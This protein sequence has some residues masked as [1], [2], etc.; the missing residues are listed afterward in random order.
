MKK[1]I[2]D[3]DPGVDDSIAIA[4]SIKS[5]LPIAAICTVYGNC[6]TNESTENTLTILELVDQDIPV[7]KG[8]VEPLSGSARRAQSHGSR[9]LGGFTLPTKRKAQS[10]SAVEYYQQVLTESE[11]Q[12]VT[13]IAIGPTTNLGLL[14]QSAPE[15]LQ[16]AEKVIIMG[17]VFGQKGNVT[18]YAEFNVYNDPVAL[19]LVLFCHKNVI[20]VPANICRQVTFKKEVFD[21]INNKQLAEGLV[22]I[23]EVFISY[24]SNKSE[25]GQFDGGVMY[26]LLATA[27]EFDPELFQVEEASVNVE[28][29]DKERYGLT[30]LG[31]GKPNCQIVTSVNAEGIKKLYIDVMNR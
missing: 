29:E 22:K 31:E 20:I 21:G 6:S 9:G 4:F 18:P 26:D 5:G 2:I 14:A 1:I 10:I 7:Y 25:Y 8:A 23:S 3:T 28:T 11:P 24:Y 19:Q 30:K 16:K 17:G 15:L 27:L 12:S 13:I